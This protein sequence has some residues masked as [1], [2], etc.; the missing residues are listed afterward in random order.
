MPLAISLLAVVAAIVGWKIFWPGESSRYTAAKKVLQTRSEIRMTFGATHERG[1]VASEK[2]TFTNIDGVGKVAYEGTNR[3][4][5]AIARF[6]AGVDGYEIATLFGQA[7]QDGI[8]ELQSK[9]PRGD[10]S[11]FTSASS[12]IET[13]HC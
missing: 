9:P 6:T 3:K 8:W 4:G 5:T 1:A 10:T 12:M 11:S 13:F 2:L 7:V